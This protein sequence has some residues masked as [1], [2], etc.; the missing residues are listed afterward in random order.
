[1]ERALFRTGNVPPGTARPAGPSWGAPVSELVGTPFL[2]RTSGPGCPVLPPACLPGAV[3]LGCTRRA[4]VLS[5]LSRLGRAKRQGLP[6]PAWSL[7]ALV[8][9]TSLT[10]A[11]LHRGRSLMPGAIAT[12]T[13]SEVHAGRGASAVF[14]GCFLGR[15]GKSRITISV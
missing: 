8:L 5:F 13:G 1:M 14:P 10:S 3:L 4:G 6:G 12:F 15:Q 9:A 11:R 7:L 2:G